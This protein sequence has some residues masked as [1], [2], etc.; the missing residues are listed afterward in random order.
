MKYARVK[1]ITMVHPKR[2]LL[3][4]LREMEQRMIRGRTF[5]NVSYEDISDFIGHFEAFVEGMPLTTSQPIRP[6]T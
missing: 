3:D 5:A 6:L 1:A 4:S 2:P